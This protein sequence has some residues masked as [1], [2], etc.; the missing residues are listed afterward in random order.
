[1]IKYEGTKMGRFEIIEAGLSRQVTRMGEFGK[2][3][4]RFTGAGRVVNGL[5][6]EEP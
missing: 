2:T 5:I 3:W 1:M 6:I 4:Q